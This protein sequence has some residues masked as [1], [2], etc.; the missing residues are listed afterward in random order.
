LQEAHQAGMAH[1][2]PFRTPSFADMGLKKCTE[3]SERNF[4]R[5]AREDSGA[6]FPAPELGL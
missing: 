1:T 5:A 2:K 4:C 6:T 3:M